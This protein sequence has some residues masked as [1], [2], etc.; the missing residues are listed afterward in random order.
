MIISFH[1][2]QLLLEEKSYKELYKIYYSEYTSPDG[3][4]MSDELGEEILNADPTENKEY[5]QWLFNMF[6]KYDFSEFKIELVNVKEILSIY[7]QGK[8]RLPR[9]NPYKNINNIKTFDELREIANYI[10][11]NEL[12]ISKKERLK[13]KKVKSRIAVHDEYI[14][15]HDDPEWKIIIPLSHPQS[16]FWADGASWCTASPSNDMGHFETYS[17]DS[18]LY[19]FHNKKNENLNHQLYLG[20][21]TKDFEFKDFRNQ[22]VS[23][24]EFIAKYPQ[25]VESLLEFWKTKDPVLKKSLGIFLRNYLQNS[26]KKVDIIL[27]MIYQTDVFLDLSKENLDKIILIGLETLNEKIIKTY[28][29]KFPNAINEE[30]ENGMTPLIACIKSKFPTESLEQEDKQTAMICKYLISKGADGSGKKNNGKSNVILEAMYEKKFKTL[31]LIKD[32]PNITKDNGSIEEFKEKAA[33]Q[34]TAL[35]ITPNGDTGTLSYKE[36]SDLLSTFIDIGMDIN[37]TTVGA[38]KY[39]PLVLSIARYIKERNENILEIINK[40]LEFGADPC[41]SSEL[42][43]ENKIPI[44]SVPNVN[45][46]L[47]EYKQKA[48]C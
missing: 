47:Q 3:V 32:L 8:Q 46:I 44:E 1:M 17:K 34:L 22:E 41:F 19:I 6:K 43:I 23:F 42:I 14:E 31:M 16:K 29:D 48:G 18:P 35:R 4:Q 5:R 10:Q 45:T 7:N 24:D 11:E 26:K 13:E 12:H 33:I 40:L 2:Y 25:F 28:F 9:E 27:G 30:L 37:V 20:A 39:N 15:I 36:F 21:L 38:R